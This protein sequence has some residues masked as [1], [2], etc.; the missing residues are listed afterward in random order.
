V[1]RSRQLILTH[2]VVIS[3]EILSS[4]GVGVD[5]V[6]PPVG[7]DKSARETEGC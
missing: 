3:P 2:M 7:P 5:S 1:L 6:D 4:R